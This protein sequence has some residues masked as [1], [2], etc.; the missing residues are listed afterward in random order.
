MHSGR[1]SHVHD[2]R[3]RL[4]LQYSFLIDEIAAALAFH[5]GD[6]RATIETLL[7]NNKFLK[8]Q[9]AITQT[10]MSIRL[11]PQLAAKL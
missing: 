11:Y 10:G 3:R 6:V 8:E 7:K 2:Q 4:R 5:D 9:L 1:R